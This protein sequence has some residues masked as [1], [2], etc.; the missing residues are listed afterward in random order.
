MT[1]PL[2]VRSEPELFEIYP[3][4]GKDVRWLFRLVKLSPGRWAVEGMVPG[5]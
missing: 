1:L 3:T 4:C 2:T 5:V